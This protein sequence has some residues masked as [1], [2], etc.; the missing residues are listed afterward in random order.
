MPISVG[1]LGLMCG[2]DGIGLIEDS[3]NKVLIIAEPWP[4]HRIR[5]GDDERKLIEELL[6][7]GA[8]SP[9]TRG[10]HDI[11]MHP[12][13]PVDIRHNAKIFREQLAVWAAKKLG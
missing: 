3:L 5:S 7:L 2:P 4:Q 11:F 6:A 13:L 8:K 10:I 12:S 1:R 9:L